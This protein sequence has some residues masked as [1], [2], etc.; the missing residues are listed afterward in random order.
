MPDFGV[1]IIRNP[2]PNTEIGYEGLCGSRDKEHDSFTKCL[3]I[4]EAR[5]AEGHLAEVLTVF[6]P[7]ESAGSCQLEI[8]DLDDA[9]DAGGVLDDDEQEKFDAANEA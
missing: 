2:G 1:L 8:Y 5:R 7:D 9:A 6:H 3:E 4:A